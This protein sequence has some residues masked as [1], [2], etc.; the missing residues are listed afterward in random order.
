MSKIKR[1][2]EENIAELSRKTGY[3]YCFLNDRLNEVITDG[4]DWDYFVGVT[5]EKDW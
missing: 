3:D 1:F 2:V 4:G 5:M